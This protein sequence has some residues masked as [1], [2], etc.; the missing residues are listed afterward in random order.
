MPGRV[1]QSAARSG[2]YESAL[3]NDDRLDLRIWLRL[4]TCTNLIERRVRQNLRRSFDFTLPRFDLLA[5]LDRAGDGLTMGALSARLMVSNGNVTGLI[6][7]LVAEGL[8]ERKTAVEDRRAQRV[9]LTR[10]GKKAFD[11]MTPEHT[12]WVHEMLGGVAREDMEGL[13]ALLGK[14]KHSLAR[15]EEPGESDA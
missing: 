6:D 7:R 10:A 2:D 8:V 13:Y 14:L 5:Q 3:T 12:R 4:L 11:T 9:R 1:Q 15:E